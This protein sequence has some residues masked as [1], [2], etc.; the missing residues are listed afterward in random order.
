MANISTPQAVP[1]RIEDVPQ[2]VPTRIEDIRVVEAVSP[3]IRETTH[4]G[5]HT[6]VT[7]ED[8][9]GLHPLYFPDG[10]KGDTPVRGLDYWTQADKSEVVRE[11][12][13]GISGKITSLTETALVS[14]RVVEAVGIPEYISNLA[15]WSAYGLTDTGWYIFARI[16]AEQGTLVTSGTLVAG[17]AGAILTIGA[18]YVDVA[19]RFGVAAESQTVMVNWGSYTDTF[20][21]KA[22][23]LA[24]RNLDYRTTFYVYDLAPFVT[25]EYALTS[26]QTFVADKQYF[27]KDGDEYSPATVTAGEAVPA[28]TYY[29]HSKII[30]QGMT[31]NITYRLDAIIDC[32]SEV[33]LPEVDDDTHGCWFEFQLRHS[34]K[35]SMTLT[36]PEGVKI[37]TEHTQAEDTGFNLIDLHYM[38]IDGV[39]MWRFMNTHSSIPT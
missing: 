7:I 23:D 3:R 28:D 19:V 9:N 18:A 11:A 16:H 14:G 26:D 36:P 34:G 8:I 15:P 6:V 27:T 31:R 5:S 4:E 24:V 2:A 33:V 35:Y 39:K 21:F 22:T 37:A 38:C 10:Q 32:A 13:G 17:A 29:N 20:V 1:T 25:W 12:S 30:I